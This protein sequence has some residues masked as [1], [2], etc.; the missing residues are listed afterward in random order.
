MIQ[1]FWHTNMSTG[2]RTARL[3]RDAVEQE[4]LD[5]IVT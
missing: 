4:R 3:V 5:E 2:R 1:R